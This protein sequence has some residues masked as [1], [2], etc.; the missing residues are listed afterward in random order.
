MVKAN[1]L[2]FELN[3]RKILNDIS[4][5]INKNDKIGLVGKNGSGKSTLLNILAGNISDNIKGSLN[6]EGN[7]I[8]ILKQEISIKYI[9]YSIINYLK[10]SCDILRLEKKINNFDF[11]NEKLDNYYKMLERFEFLDGYNFENKVIKYMN[12]LNLKK[13]CNTK[14]EKLSGGEK[15]KVLIMELF[16]KK[17]NI[18]LLD[19]PTNNL[20][21]ETINYLKNNL[22]NV[23]ETIII[24]SHDEEFLKDV[25]NR[26]FVLNN[27]NLETYNVGYDEYL[28]LKHNEYNRNMVEYEKAQKEKQTLKQRIEKAKEWENKGKSKKAN[29]DND[30]IANNYAKEKTKNADISKLNK[31]LEELK[32]PEFKYK[33]NLDYF[34]KFDKE[35]GNKDII[36][37]NL[38]CGYCDFK[39]PVLNLNIN[40]G[41]KISIIGNNG[42]GKTTF[43]KTLI[44]EIKPIRGNI[45]I[46]RTVKFGYI[47][48]DSFL[49]DE[50]NKITIFNYITKGNEKNDKTFIF[51]ILNK[52]DI[53]YA[54]RNKLYNSLSPGERTRVNLAKFAATNTNVIILDEPTNHLDIE[55]IKIIYDLIKTYKGTIISI[56]H[57]KKYNELLKP[58]KILNMKSGEVIA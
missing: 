27:G 19:E 25:V 4:F 44:G 15:L 3:G 2:F 40:F 34:F 57:N 50:S 52:F 6:L 10:E 45:K 8:A 1:N 7:K 32:I 30:K 18:I 26:V 46:G 9:N 55:G 16:L 20:D 56:S 58:N 21:T 53:K 37:S 29:S 17:A 11:N 14:I 35:K 51:N 43:I 42:T 13:D 48:Q 38:I 39:T 47:S 36:I 22:K 23:T 54:D 28:I 24:V 33:Q 5:C 49:N 41:D 12:D 31:E